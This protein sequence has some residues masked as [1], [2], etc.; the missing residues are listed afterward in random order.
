MLSL[1]PL[2]SDLSGD[3]RFRKFAIEI[4]SVLCDPR[5][6]FYLYWINAY[7]KNGN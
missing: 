2:N 1:L 4:I 3:I 5:K 7:V 6:E